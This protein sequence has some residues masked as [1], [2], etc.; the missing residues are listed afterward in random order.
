ML[1][2]PFPSLNCLISDCLFCYIG[3]YFII[4]TLACLCFNKKMPGD[5]MMSSYQE[6][7]ASQ[8][9]DVAVCR[10]GV[11]PPLCAGQDRL[12]PC[13]AR[14]SRRAGVISRLVLCELDVCSGSHLLPKALGDSCPV[15][16]T[17]CWMDKTGSNCCLDGGGA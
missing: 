5:E 4:L 3:D 11:A 14:L 8:S 17:P 15:G 12:F 9:E 6:N 16:M 2:L 13:G 1:R 10:A 7:S